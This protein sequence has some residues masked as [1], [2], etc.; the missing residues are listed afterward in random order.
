MGNEVAVIRDYDIRDRKLV[1]ATAQTTIES[2]DAIEM[3]TTDGNQVF[4]DK[5]SF[6][7]AV[8]QAFTASDPKTF[9]KLLGMN[10][11]GPMGIGA[12]DLASV[13]GVSSGTFLPLTGG[14]MDSN[15]VITFPSQTTVYGKKRISFG[16]LY[17]DGYGNCIFDTTATDDNYWNVGKKVGTADTYMFTVHHN[18]KVG[19]G[20]TSP[21]YKL[22]VNGEAAA[23]SFVN[24]SDIRKK[25]II[26]NLN[27]DVEDIAKAPIFKF[28]WIDPEMPEGVNVGTSAQYWQ[29]IIPEIVTEADDDDKTLSMQYGVAGLVSSIALARKVVEQEETIKVQEARIKALEDALVEIQS[30]LNN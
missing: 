15:A 9:T 19:I 18:G 7:K 24:T 21:S 8:G 30:K 6:I 1:D 29:T 27:L 25:D 20:T 16:E 12:S 26:E 2:T 11:D 4:I 3:K 28:S 22:H 17:M 13:L 10:G 23:T 5:A 14:T